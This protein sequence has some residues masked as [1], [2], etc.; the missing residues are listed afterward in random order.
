MA[1]RCFGQ[2]RI[3]H[4]RARLHHRQRG[5]SPDSGGRRR[6]PSG[7]HLARDG[8]HDRGGPPHA[9]GRVP[10]SPL[11]A[12]ARLHA[13]PRPLPARKRPVR[14]LSHASSAHRVPRPP[15]ARRGRHAADRG[16]HPP[17]DVPEDRARD[18]HGAH[19]H[20]HDGRPRTRPG[21]R[22]LHRR[23]PPLV[24]DLLRLAAHR[25]PRA[26]DD[27]DLRPR[28]SGD[29]R[30][31][32]RARRHRADERRLVRNRAPVHVPGNDG[33]RHRGRTAALLVR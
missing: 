11:R 16:G 32:S 3:D 20:G 33:V 22:R 31:E 15:G 12:E 28:G 9:A 18:G 26:G 5:A 1:R 14:T 17:S 23:S 10:R 24:V 21:A 19:G 25:S 6:D 29:P 8:L 7:D 13:V 2:L 4:G 30:E 27:L